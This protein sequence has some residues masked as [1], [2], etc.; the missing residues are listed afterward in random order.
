MLYPKELQPQP[1][2][3]AELDVEPWL[4]HLAAAC[5]VLWPHAT[6]TS[7]NKTTTLPLAASEPYRS[8]GEDIKIY[9]HGS[10]CPFTTAKTVPSGEPHSG[11][12]SQPR[13]AAHAAHPG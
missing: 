1:G 8:Q 13:V 2:V 9:R 6:E 3:R 5:P 7:V 4:R 12:T 10:F 11:S